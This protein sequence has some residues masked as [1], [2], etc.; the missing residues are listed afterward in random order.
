MGDDA[1]RFVDWLAVAGQSWWLML[2]VGPPDRHRSPYKARSAFATWDGLLADPDAPVSGREADA[3][4]RRHAFW[5]DGW[6]RFGGSVEDQVR[7]DREWGALRTYAAQRGVRLI[8][9]VP[10]YVADGGADVAAWPEIFQ[11]G[12]VAGAPPDS[13]SADGQHWG[14]PLYDWPALQRRGYRWWTERFRRVFDLFDV[15][16]VD[17]FRGFVAYWAIPE[18]DQRPVNGAWRRGPGAA[19]FRAAERALGRL[20]LIA[21]DLGVITDPVVRLR[22]ELG[23]PGMVV[24]QFAFEEDPASPHRFANHER[25]SV[26]FTGTHD[27]AP[28]AGWWAHAD[29]ETRSR[30]LAAMAAAGVPADDDPVWRL[31][32][33]TMTSPAG[34]AIVQAQDILGLGDEAR[35]NMPGVE[36]GPN[37]RWRLE[38]GQLDGALAARLRAATERTGRG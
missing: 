23:Y 2:P 31:I 28:L 37:W 8:G 12:F 24:T 14:N 20:P 4:R 13:F 25:E 16:R 17:H 33:L 5:I 26:A 1:R 11:P 38:G 10:I 6:E 15:V 9:D 34:L 22:R 36:G 7:F 18:H 27:H 21:E 30:A 19:P 3:F 29:E 35:M 32:D